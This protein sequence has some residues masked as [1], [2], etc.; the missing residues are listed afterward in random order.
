M[1]VNNERVDGGDDHVDSE[2][3]FVSL[4]EERVVDVVLRESGVLDLAAVLAAHVLF[5]V[6]HFECVVQD[7]DAHAAVYAEADLHDVLYGVFFLVLGL[8]GWKERANG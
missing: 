6:F 2:V 3:E 4:V 1:V 8:D 5:A 7:F